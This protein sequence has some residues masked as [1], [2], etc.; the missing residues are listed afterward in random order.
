MTLK[1]ELIAVG[2]AKMISKEMIKE[3]K[4]IAVTTDKVFMLPGTYPKM[5]K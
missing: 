2:T 3:E 1:N 4:G 5:D